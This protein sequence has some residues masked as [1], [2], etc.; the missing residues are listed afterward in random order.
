MDEIGRADE[1]CPARRS[2]R[3][4]VPLAPSRVQPHPCPVQ[5]RRRVLAGTTFFSTLSPDELAAVDRQFV[6]RVYPADT[7]ICRAGEPAQ[8]LFVLGAGRVKL[9]RHASAGADVVVDVVLPGAMFG[10]LPS[11]AYAAYGESAETLTGC[12]VLAIPVSRFK[13]LLR[14][15]PEVTMA[16]IGSLS[17]HLTEARA[18]LARLGTD[19]VEQRIAATLLSLAERAGHDRPDMTLVQIPLA[20]ADLAA[21]CGTTTESVSRTLSRWRRAGVIESG[22]RWVGIADVDALRAISD[23][24]RKVQQGTRHRSA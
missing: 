12:C 22:R 4:Q 24:Q 1:P 3:R 16:V 21:M 17:D 2:C 10:A 15:H 14:V 13:E 18:A 20:R 7:P 9:T 11:D 6:A 19:S 5:V 8:E 23:G